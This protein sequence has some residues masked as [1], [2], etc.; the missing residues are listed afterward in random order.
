MQ[1]KMRLSTL[2]LLG[3]LPLAGFGADYGSPQNPPTSGVIGGQIDTP[4]AS[5]LNRDQTGDVPREFRR[6]DKDKD[7]MISRDEAKRSKDTMAQFDTLDADHDG[8]ISLSEWQAA[9]PGTGMGGVS[10]SSR[11]TNPP[12]STTS[13]APGSTTGT[14]PGSGGGMGMPQY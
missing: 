2:I 4:S 6:M 10:G 8:K 7:G 9:H 3:A 14:P 5:G 12:G 1:S 11:E 13:P